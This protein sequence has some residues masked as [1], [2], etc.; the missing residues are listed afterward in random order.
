[1]MRHNPSQNDAKTILKSITSIRKHLRKINPTPQVLVNNTSQVARMLKIPAK[2]P[3]IVRR[4]LD[5]AVGRLN[6]YEPIALN[7]ST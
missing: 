1:M 4:L 2:R 6:D 5:I 7:R 3:I